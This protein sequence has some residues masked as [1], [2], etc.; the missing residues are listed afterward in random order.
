MSSSDAMQIKEL[1]IVVSVAAF[2]TIL[3][4]LHSTFESGGNR[5]TEGTLTSLIQRLEASE[6]QRM[7]DRQ[8]I[9]KAGR[10]LAVMRDQVRG[11]LNK[12]AASRFAASNLKVCFV[13]HNPRCHPPVAHGLFP[14]PRIPSQA[15]HNYREVDDKAN[16]QQNLTK[17]LL[18]NDNTLLKTLSFVTNQLKSHPAPLTESKL[19]HNRMANSNPTAGQ[20]AALSRM[21]LVEATSHPKCMKLVE[22]TSHPMWG[23]NT[24]LPI[25]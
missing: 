1:F 25:P 18:N 6:K 15:N 4:A 14:L 19:H 20:L 12:D 9:E 21:K 23:R 13:S 17:R 16:L 7:S 3:L 22:A 5:S 2:V 8:V 11:L 10:E 24:P